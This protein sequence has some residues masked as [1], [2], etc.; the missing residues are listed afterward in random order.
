MKTGDLVSTSF[1]GQTLRLGKALS[2]GGQGAVFLAEGEPLVVKLY[3]PS[4]VTGV[5]GEAQRH[6]LVSMISEGPPSESFVW[7]QDLVEQPSLGYVMSRVP[8]RFVPLRQLLW[9]AEPIGWAMRV[10]ICFHLVQA[11]ARLHLRRG[12]VYCDLS[13]DNVLCDLHTGKVRII[14]TDNV[15]IQG[16]PN[17][18]AV[19]GTRRYMAP[20]LHAGKSMTPTIETDLHSVAVVIFETMLLHNPFLGDRVIEGPPEEEDVA[21]GPRALY[22]YHPIDTRNRYTKYREHGGV[23]P[24][25][26]PKSLL[27]LFEETLTIGLADPRKRVRESRW[28][29]VLTDCLDLFVRCGNAA[30]FTGGTFI[31]PGSKL[32][33]CPGCSTPLPNFSL[34]D[35]FDSRGHHIRTKVIRGNEWLASH[36]CN[37]SEPFNFRRSDAYARVEA[38]PDHGVTLRNVSRQT[39]LYRGP[40]A[41]D[42]SAF[43]PGKR[44]VLLTGTRIQFG[45]STAVAG[46][47]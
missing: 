20:E 29:R 32:R 44:L 27:G 37:P 19:I 35:F 46:A 15:T 31:K 40:N 3:H 41:T 9:N 36:H 7:P 28:Q 13:P 33:D 42:W 21:L 4:L 5:R 8:N 12:S 38:V 11:L 14:D 47:Q 22:I 10:S 34:L 26:L 2:P 1:R 6:H 39:F 17:L 43:P 30:C 25:F 45:S 18:L 16:E 23:P 24:D